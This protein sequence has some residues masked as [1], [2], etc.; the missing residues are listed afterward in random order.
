MIHSF[1]NT[2]DLC[3]EGFVDFYSLHD[4][5]LGMSLQYHCCVCD[6]CHA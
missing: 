3:S 2:V 6:W 1:Y 5:S 4:S